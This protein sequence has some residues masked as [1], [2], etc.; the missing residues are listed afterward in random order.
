MR[1]PDPIRGR[2]PSDAI[3]R[4]RILCYNCVAELPSTVSFFAVRLRGRVW[5]EFTVHILSKFLGNRL[6]PVEDGETGESMESQLGQR[7]QHVRPSG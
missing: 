6:Y 4:S 7:N 5:A 2:E 1:V 3:W